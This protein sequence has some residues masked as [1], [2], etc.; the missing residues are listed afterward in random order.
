MA[1]FYKK[2]EDC[3]GCGGKNLTPVLDLGSMPPANSFIKASEISKEKQFPLT[4]VFCN[5]CKLLQVPEV[6]DPGVLFS[7]YDYLTSASAPLVLHFKKMAVHIA[8]KFSIK[9]ED[10]VVEIGGN[11]GVLLEALV[12][13]CRTLNVEPAKNVAELSRNKGIETINDFFGPRLAEDI[14]GKY[15][16]A[17]IVVANNVM[18]HIDDMRGIFSGV[19]SVVGDKGVFVFEVHWVGNLLGDGGFDQIYHEHL[20]YYS[21]ISLKNLVERSGL[22]IFDIEMVP[23]HGESMRVYAGKSREPSIAVVEMLKKEKNMKLDKMET[24]LNFKN[25]VENNQNRLVVLLTDIKKQGKSIVG[26]GAPA[27]GNTL[28]N[29]CK[30]DGKTVDYII[31]T[32]PFK[33]GLVAPGSHIPIYS[34][35]KLKE[36]RPDYVLL[37]AWNY[38][39]AIIKK[40][41]ELINA[42]TKFILPVPEPRII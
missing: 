26:Y 6:V 13:K 21:L 3:R 24:F 22:K 12:D 37:S 1:K 5:D 38:A 8:E 4:V 31:D 18:A 10:L 19:S 40:E 29:F 35:E 41:S 27:K 32:T 34:P 23:M 39:D 11:D 14:V 25:K 9:K 36:S 42:G 2:R 20:C 16:H 7:E 28:L 15:G 17:N 30:I 33:Q